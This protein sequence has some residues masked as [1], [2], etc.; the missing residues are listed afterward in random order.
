MENLITHSDYLGT[1]GSERKQ[2]PN[3]LN[4]GQDMFKNT[5]YS[6]NKNK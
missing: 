5:S 6:I 3:N 4:R 2:S 1:E